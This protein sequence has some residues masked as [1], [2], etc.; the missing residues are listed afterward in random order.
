MYEKLKTSIIHK[1]L[2]IN[3]VRLTKLIDSF[4]HLLFHLSIFNLLSLCICKIDQQQCVQASGHQKKPLRPMS[5]SDKWTGGE[6]EWNDPE[7]YLF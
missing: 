3:Y 7:V 4:S 6:D 2:L 1:N 5:S